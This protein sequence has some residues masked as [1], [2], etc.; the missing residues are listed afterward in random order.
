MD[1]TRV[2]FIILHTHHHHRVQT[3]QHPRVTVE[4]SSHGVD[5]IIDP[6]LHHRPPVARVGL[7]SARSCALRY[8]R[9]MYRNLRTCDNNGPPLRVA[10][11]ET[12]V[13]TR[14]HGSHPDAYFL[15]NIWV[16]PMTTA[17]GLIAL[18]PALLP[19]RLSFARRS[20]PVPRLKT[21]G[22]WWQ[23]DPKPIRPCGPKLVRLA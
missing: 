22:S 13:P 1:R 6:C 5:T 9:A 15:A 2:H 21:R 14:I 10:R 8:S 19:R 4:P 12:M 17:I 18:T 20:S 11:R 16:S 7:R 3:S 23:T